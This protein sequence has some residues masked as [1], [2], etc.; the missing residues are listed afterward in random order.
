MP[1]LAAPVLDGLARGGQQGRRDGVGVERRASGPRGASTPSTVTETA[2][3]P[4][5][6]ELAVE[7]A[8][9]VAHPGLL[10]AERGG[11]GSG[12]SAATLPGDGDRGRRSAKCGWAAWTDGEQGAD[13]EGDVLGQL[14]GVSSGVSGAGTRWG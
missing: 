14:A 6:R 2:R 3:T 11:R 9:E 13:P 12:E 4:V 1:D 7:A 8:H 10:H 5:G